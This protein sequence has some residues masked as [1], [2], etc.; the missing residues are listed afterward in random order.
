MIGRSR[1]QRAGSAALITLLLATLCATRAHADAD[2]I[3]PEAPTVVRAPFTLIV[4]HAEKG[5]MTI[6]IKDDE[7]FVRRADLVEAGI[8]VPPAHEVEIDGE[9]VLSLK[10]L[11]PPLSY[12]LNENTI[13]LAITAPI[14]LLPTATL[15]FTGRPPDVVYQKN[16]S[17]FVNYAPRIT[18]QGKIDLYEE[19]GVSVGGD[20]LFSSAYL[21]NTHKPVRGISNFLMDDHDKL[22]RIT[23][24]DAMVLTGPLGSGHFIGGVTIARRFELDP[25][26]MKAPALGYVGTTMTPA[27][28]DVYVNGARVRTENLQPGTFRLD[29]LRVGGG[30]GIATYVVR[31]VFGHEQTITAPFYISEGV[32]RKGLQDYTYSA[33]ELRNRVGTDS[34]DYGEG[35]LLGRHRIGISDHLTLGGRAE[36]SYAVLSG[37]PSVTMLTPIGQIEVELG[38]SRDVTAGAGLASFL[39]YGYIS[40]HFGA[41]LFGRAVTNRYA[42]VDQRANI[43]R[44]IGEVGIY[45]ATPIGSSLTLSAQASYSRYRDRGT[46]LRGMLQSSVRVGRRANLFASASKARNQDGSAPWEVMLTFNYSFADRLN[47]AISPRLDD[48]RP[49]VLLD[50]NRS[51][52]VGQGFGYRASGVVAEHSSAEALVQYQTLFGRYGAEYAY[53]Q[54][55]HH[56]T[57]EAAGALAIV[58]GIGLFPTLPIQDGFAVIRT[59]GAKNVRGY[60]NNQELGRTDRNGNLLVPNLLSYYGNHLGIAQEDV[61]IQYGIGA[62][63]M[64]LAPPTRGAAIADFPLTIPHFYRGHVIVD[65]HGAQVIP[66]YGDIRVMGPKGEISSPLGEEAEFELEGVQPGK[67]TFA[68][69][70]TG[71][72]CEISLDIADSDNTVIDLGVLTCKAP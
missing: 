35:V 22:R 61:P 16:T 37:G 2:I 5:E 39:S 19:A 10:A 66:K 52:P 40:R 63:D 64:T 38:V 43:D 26:V 69:D 46:N 34:W 29:N 15:D 3:E 45:E 28:L 12:E 1:G 31:D 53:D 58:P 25:Y 8:T 32:L 23:L 9:Q 20:L 72:T 54:S 6:L 62:T 44:A 65:E 70:Y 71:G 48:G 11:C 33:G 57:L 13:T 18:E 24:G 4:N 21:S 27:T 14:S 55:Q 50:A 42:T 59:A 47:A 7:V 30:S 36:A 49:S 60:V 17:A 51:L 41:G 56:L 68:I 67:R